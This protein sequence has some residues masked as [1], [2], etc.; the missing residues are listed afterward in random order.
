MY[1]RGKQGVLGCLGGAE[2][3]GAVFHFGERH[4][5]GPGLELALH[6]G[7]GREAH[8]HGADVVNRHVLGFVAAPG[9]LYGGAYR[10]NGLGMM[11][12]G[13]RFHL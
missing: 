10:G 9:G 2:S 11:G 12:H 4:A 3:G 8:A 7:A 6:V 13:S 5:L 1:I